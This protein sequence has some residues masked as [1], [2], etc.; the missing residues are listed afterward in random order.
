[1][2]I[3]NF[4]TTNLTLNMLCQVFAI[5]KFPR[6]KSWI[7]SIYHVDSSNIFMPPR[8]SQVRLLVVVLIYIYITVMSF[9]CI[10]PCKGNFLT[11]PGLSRHQNSCLI[12][13]TAQ[14]LKIE[15]RRLIQNK[16][17]ISTL[18]ARKIRITFRGSE[19]SVSSLCLRN[20]GQNE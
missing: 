6:E 7:C 20:D 14:A 10:H 8:L 1:M 12:F 18:K 17:P 13:R 9:S 5:K 4:W 15:N 16:A 2:S 19:I 3:G 11:R